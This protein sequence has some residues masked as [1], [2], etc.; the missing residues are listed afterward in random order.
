[1][2]SSNEPSPFICNFPDCSGQDLIASSDTLNLSP[3][4]YPPNS[5]INFREIHQDCQG[6]SEVL[7]FLSDEQKKNKEDVQKLKE[8][9]Q[10]LKEDTQNLQERMRNL[11]YEVENMKENNKFVKKTISQTQQCLRIFG[12]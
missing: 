4:I 12:L 3:W 5:S 1:M 8:D 11:Q 10:K 2:R 9:V 6:I 7:K